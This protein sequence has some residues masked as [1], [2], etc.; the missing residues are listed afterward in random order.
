M[1]ISG[2]ERFAWR[3]L[4]LLCAW[5][6]HRPNR[7]RRH[8]R[9]THAEGRSACSSQWSHPLVNPTRCWCCVLTPANARPYCR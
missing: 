2:S 1:S 5:T 3:C 8:T 6:F 4:R 7:D 9:S